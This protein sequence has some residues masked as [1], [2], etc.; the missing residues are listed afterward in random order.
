MSCNFL[1]SSLSYQ[2]SWVKHQIKMSSYETNITGS[3]LALHC[4]KAHAKR[5]KG[6]STPCK[7]V[8]HENLNMKLGRHDYVVDIT[9]HAIFGWIRFSEGF[10]SN[11]WNRT[12]LWLFW[13]SCFF[14]DPTYRSKYGANFHASW[15]K[16]RASTQGWS[17]WGLGQLMTSF[18]ENMPPEHS[19]RGA[20][21]Q[22][23]AKSQRSLS[24]D[25]IKTTQSI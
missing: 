17:F 18:G 13:L 3:A 22:F 2:T 25:I 4:C 24:F 7:I 15:L 21:R 19:K 16:R 8:T 1:T 12:P 5:E 9:H 6:N 23:P 11:G 20:N 10:S 14:F